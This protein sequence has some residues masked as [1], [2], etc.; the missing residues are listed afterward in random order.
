MMSPTRILR[1]VETDADC[2]GSAHEGEDGQWNA[3]QIED[4]ND[5]QDAQC[6]HR[7]ATNHAGHLLVDMEALHHDPLQSPGEDGKQSVAEREQE[8]PADALADGDP[9]ADRHR[10]ALDDRRVLDDEHLE[11]P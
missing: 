3:G 8:Q 6:N 11:I 5:Q 7:P 1:W 2:Q 4:E 10:F 9:V